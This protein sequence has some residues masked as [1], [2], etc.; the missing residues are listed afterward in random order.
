M[1]SQGKFDQTFRE[2][3]TQVLL[4]LFKKKKIAEEGTF[5][6]SFCVAAI[7]L[8]PKPGKDTTKKENYRPSSSM[9]IDANILNKI[10]A[11]L[12]Q[13]YGLPWWLRW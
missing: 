10:L 11:N 9:N 12:I 6:I 13:Q 2:V 3:L 5:P 4:K 1:A 7:I 8:V